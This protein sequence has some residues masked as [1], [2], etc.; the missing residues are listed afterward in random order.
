MRSATTFPFSIR[1]M[2]KPP[3]IAGAALSGWPSISAVMSRSSFLLKGSPISRFARKTPE[4]SAAELLPSPLAKGIL[5]IRYI[6]PPG[7]VRP[8]LEAVTFI[9]LIIILSRPVVI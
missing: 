1:A 4:A 8:A 3:K 9:A 6:L 2:Q 5:L 7:S